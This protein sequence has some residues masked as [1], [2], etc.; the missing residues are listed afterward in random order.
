MNGIDEQYRQLD[1]V[2]SSLIKKGVVKLNQ[3]MDAESS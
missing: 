1:K 3:F 2:N